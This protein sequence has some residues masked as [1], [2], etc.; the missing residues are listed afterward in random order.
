METL[1]ES[2]GASTADSALRLAL[3]QLLAGRRGEASATLGAQ[4]TRAD[5]SWKTALLAIALEYR[6]V[7]A[8]AKSPRR[9]ELERLMRTYL[10]NGWPH[11]DAVEAWAEQ[12]DISSKASKP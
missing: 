4:T 2:P 5:G 8:N 10:A 7:H 11:A 3:A 12:V 6:A 9:A 1:T